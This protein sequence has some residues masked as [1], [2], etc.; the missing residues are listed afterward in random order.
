M[1]YKVFHAQWKYPVKDDWTITV[2]QDLKDLNINLSLDEMKR[3]T[4][5]N[6]KRLVKVKT[7]EYALQYLLKLKQ[8]HSKWKIYNTMN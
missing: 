8:K 5:W 3:K 1:L 4:E 2:K 6:F 7:K